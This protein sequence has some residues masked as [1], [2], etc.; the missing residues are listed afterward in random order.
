[1]PKPLKG[2][3]LAR[4]AQKPQVPSLARSVPKPLKGPSPARSVT[5]LKVT[6]LTRSVHKPPS[7]FIGGGGGG[8]PCTPPPRVKWDNKRLSSIPNNNYVIIKGF[9]VVLRADRCS[10]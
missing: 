3:S 10:F 4:S 8:A 9:P 1:M 5:K 7:I 6:T 2:P